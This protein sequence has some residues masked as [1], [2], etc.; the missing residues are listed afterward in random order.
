MK[1]SIGVLDKRS[2]NATLDKVVGELCIIF[3][4]FNNHL[5]ILIEYYSIVNIKVKNN[6]YLYYYRRKIYNYIN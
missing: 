4:L 3:F 2:Y 6:K 5:T 1:C